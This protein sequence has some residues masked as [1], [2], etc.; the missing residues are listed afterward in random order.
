MAAAAVGLAAAAGACGIAGELAPRAALLEASERAGLVHARLCKHIGTRST[1]H[2]V[3]LIIP[4]VECHWRVKF[5]TSAINN[6]AP[7]GYG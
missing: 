7:L 1:P 3:G 4:E 5:R 2:G 6:V